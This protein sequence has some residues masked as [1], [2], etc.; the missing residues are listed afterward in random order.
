MEL[1][2]LLTGGDTNVGTFVT[3]LVFA[4]CAIVILGHVPRAPR[5]VARLSAE[6]LLFYLVQSLLGVLI[7]AIGGV[8]YYGSP[9]FGALIGT[10]V[11]YAFLQTRLTVTDRIVRCT[12]FASYF[13]IVVGMTT[14]FLPA[15]GWLRSSSFAEAVPSTVSYLVMLGFAVVL[16]KY[17]IGHCTYMPHV[18]IVL[19]ILV[20]FLGAAVAQSFSIGVV[21]HILRGPD[22][23]MSATFDELEQAVLLVTL[24]ADVSFLALVI[25]SY[26]MFYALA[27]E[28]DERTELLVTKKNEADALSQMRV[29]SSVYESLRKARHELKNHDA[30]MAALLKEGDYKGLEEYFSAYE[31]RNAEVLSYVSS[32]NPAVDA[33][34]NAK[35]AL[36]RAEGIKVKSILAVPPMLPLDEGDLYRL[37]ANMLDNAVEGASTSGAERPTVTIKLK[38]EGGYLFFIVTNPCDVRK[39][40]WGQAGLPLSTKKGDVHGFGTKVI[41]EIAAKY[42]GRARFTAESGVFIANVMIAMGRGE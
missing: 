36:A 17:S 32:G 22:M 18:Y 23:I 34:V 35:I 11:L 31:T 26:L 1:Y 37:L 3:E 19:I 13:V 8:T 40:R 6:F 14:V 7:H 20:D 9:S 4:L 42:R 15:M 39:L 16:R 2:N 29:A 25:V 28:H 10:L 33:I 30:Y 41:S 27:R 12:T 5:D 21:P 38:P 24:F